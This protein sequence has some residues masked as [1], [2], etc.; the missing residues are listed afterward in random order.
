MLKRV[1]LL[2]AIIFFCVSTRLLAQDQ[3][4]PVNLNL[5]G[6]DYSEPWSC[7]RCHFVY[8]VRGDHNLEAVGVRYDDNKKV[9]EMT[10]S[11]WLAS[12]HSR[13]NYRTTQ[14]TFCAKCHSPL[15][16][17]VQS[18]FKNGFMENTEPI[19]DGKV[20]GV[21]CATCHPT[22]DTARKIGRRLGIYQ[23]GKDRTTPEAYKVIKEGEE[24]SLCLN[25]HIQRH[26]TKNPAFKAMYDIGVKCIDCHMAVYGKTN[27]GKG[28]VQRRFHDFKVAMNLPFSCGTKG[29]IPGYQCH[30]EFST[31]STL[32]LIPYLKQQHKKWWPLKPG[33]GI[34]PNNADAVSGAPRLETKEDY[35]RLWKELEERVGQ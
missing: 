15:Q 32:Q 35:Y 10:G 30:N 5:P 9:F 3:P 18:T 33:G 6:Y 2:V 23:F 31:A 25:C 13:S 7:T 4:K 1:V 16:A 29:S 26:D 12:K 14:N 24:D 8:G 19:E 34:N 20:E 22:G 11:G 27:E 28:N 21:V 17:T